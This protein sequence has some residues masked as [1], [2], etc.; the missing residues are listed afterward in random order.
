MSGQWTDNGQTCSGGCNSGCLD[1]GGSDDGDATLSC[2]GKGCSNNSQCCPEAQ[3]CP[4]VNGSSGY[5][6]TQSCST[7]GDL[8]LSTSECCAPY[9]CVT[10]GGSGSGSGSSSG[11]G[12]GSSSGMVMFGG[13]CQ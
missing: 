4:N 7:Q 10:D 2:G 1:D 6:T 11:G 9:T 8:C 3:Y 13:W 12:S 5:C